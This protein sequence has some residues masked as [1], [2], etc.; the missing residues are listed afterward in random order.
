[1]IFAMIQAAIDFLLTAQNP[2][3]GWG[4]GKSKRSNTE[5]TA[6]AQLALRTLS[7]RSL[8]ASIDRGLNWLTK[9]Q[10]HDGSWPL[11]D[12]LKPGSWTTAL[13][14]LS[15]AHV[16]RHQQQ[17]LRGA[18]WLLSQEGRDPGWLNSFLYRWAPHRLATRLNPDLKG[19]PWTANAFSWV[20][21]TAYA[22]IGLKKLRPHVQSALAEDRIR[23]GELLLYDRMC[24]GGGWNYGNSVVLGEEL[25]PYPDT[26][27]IA[28]IA[29][30]DRQTAEA[31]QLSLQALQHM[32]SDVD[33]GLTLGWTILCFALYG[34]DVA[35][36]QQR[37]AR[38]YD[39]TEFLGETKTMALALLASGDGA[40]IFKV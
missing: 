8:T 24:K 6:F 18:N 5:A 10:N 25:P 33:S 32:L 40:K 28:L 29:L 3:G 9:R 38:T 27:A 11:T 34:Q 23:Q 1:V 20:E 36:L 17:A 26:T 37:L 39:K 31:N 7:D 13:V 30:H 19:W 35:T 21:P 22:L 4:T 12:Q 16:E 14:V 2:D 15:L